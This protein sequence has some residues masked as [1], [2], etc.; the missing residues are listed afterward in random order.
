ITGREINDLADLSKIEKKV[1]ENELMKYSRNAMDLYALNFKRDSP[2]S[3]NDLLYFGKVEHER[4]HKGLD[5][6]VKNGNKKS[7]EI[8]EG[9]NSHIHIIVSRNGHDNKIKL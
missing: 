2:K 1:Y 7:G 3:G 9:L 4:E 8:K 6:D 5:E